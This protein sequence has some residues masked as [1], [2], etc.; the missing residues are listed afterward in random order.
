MKGKFT[1]RSIYESPKRSSQSVNLTGQLRATFMAEKRKQIVSKM[2][3]NFE[4]RLKRRLA[5]S[6]RNVGKRFQYLFEGFATGLLELER[7][8]S[9]RLQDIEE[10]IEEERKQQEQKVQASSKYNWSK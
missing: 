4:Y 10:E 6:E 2:Q 7:D 1:E 3:A 5:I 9:H 8:Y